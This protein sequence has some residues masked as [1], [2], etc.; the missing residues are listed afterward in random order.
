MYLIFAV[1][2]LNQVT[3]VDIEVRW[4]RTHSSH[5]NCLQNMFS[6]TSKCYQYLQVSHNRKTASKLILYDR[7]YR[8][9]QRALCWSIRVH[10]LQRD[11]RD[12][13]W[14]PPIL[15]SCCPWL[16][17]CET[18]PGE[19]GS[20]GEL[21]LAEPSKLTLART[22]DLAKKLRIRHKQINDELLYPPQTITGFTKKYFC[23]ILCEISKWEHRVLWQIIELEFLK[24]LTSNNTLYRKASLD[25]ELSLRQQ[26]QSSKMGRGQLILL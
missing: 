19:D 5:W 11:P 6:N 24:T 21:L 14:V 20:Q 25:A 23:R 1:A 9:R 16:W 8:E 18:S 22:H 26:N 2:H 17:R 10:R 7:T 13:L 12:R 3:R 4:Q 15:V